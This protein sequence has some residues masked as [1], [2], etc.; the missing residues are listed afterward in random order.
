MLQGSTDGDLAGQL[1]QIA[2]EPILR[3]LVYERLGDYCHQCRNRLNSL[4]L[5]IYLMMKLTPAPTVGTW[6]EI[7]R[8]YGD[9]ERRVDQIQNLCRPMIVTRVTLELDL[10]IDDR[11]EAWTRSM[12][13]NGRTLEFVAPAERALASFDVDRLGQALDAIV[14]WRAGDE[15]AE[16]PARLLWWVESGRVHLSWEEPASTRSGVQCRPMA[17]GSIWALPLMA[18]VADAHG[19][20]C[21]LRQDRGWQLDVSWPFRPPTP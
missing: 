9:L 21:R 15:S 5:M 3:G 11:R 6:E 2:R 10:L 20:E 4:K 14:A 8:H 12:I 13:A 19:G 1:L 16:R 17:R 18:R 7:N